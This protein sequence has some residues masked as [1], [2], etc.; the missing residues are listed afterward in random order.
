MTFPKKF[1]S[2]EV[3][4]TK[5][6]N[7]CKDCP[8]FRDPCLWKGGGD[9]PAHVI[10]IGENPSG[11]SIGHSQPFYGPQGRLFKEILKF[12]KARRNGE[13]DE[14]KYYFTYGALV[15]AYKPKATHMAHC[16]RNLHRDI[17]SVKGIDGRLP[18][19]VPLGPF[20]SKALG[21]RS[22]ITDIVGRVL[23]IKIGTNT[24]KAVPLLSMTHLKAEPGLTA[25]VIAALLRAAGLAYGKT[26]EKYLPLEEITKDYVF[27]KTIEEVK[28]LVDYVINY[29]NAKS[30]LSPDRWVISLDVETNTLKPYVPDAKVLMLSVAWDDGKAA[31]IL[32]DHKETPYDPKKAWEHVG[33]LLACNK[34]KVFHGGKFDLQ[35]LEIVNNHKVNNLAWDTLLGEHYIDEDKKGHYKLKKLTNIYTPAYT[36]YEDE[37]QALLRFGTTDANEVLYLNK[38]DILDYNDTLGCPPGR[39]PVLWTELITA[40]TEGQ[41]K[42]ILQLKKNLNIKGPAKKKKKDDG[43]ASIPLDTILRYAAVDADVTRIIMKA[44]YH[45]VKATKLRDAAN[46]VMRSFYLPGS[47]TLGRMEY[48]GIKI[49][50]KHLDKIDAGV[51][52]MLEKS[53]KEL[54]R[55]FGPG[56]NYSSP[57]QVL[58]LMT[59]MNFEALP[60]VEQGS[61]AHA[62]LEQYIRHY[63]QGD[64]HRLFCE[65]MI[66]Y[67]AP[68]TAK[69]SFIKKYRLLCENDGRIHCGFGLNT[70][71][72]GRL[73]SSGPNLQNVPLRVCRI[74][75][76]DT[77]IHPGFNVKKLFIPSSDDLTLC[78][79][80][81]KGAELRVYTAYSHDDIMIKAL[82]DGLDI[83]SFVASKAFKILYEEVVV[84]KNTDPE[85]YKKRDQAKHVVFGV[86]YGAGAYTVAKQIGSTIEEAQNI[87]N[88]IFAEFPR[89]RW[90]ID[91]T[92]RKV[93]EQQYLDTYLGRRRRFRLA[94]ANNTQAENARREGINFL[95]QSTASDLVLNQMCEMDEHMDEL[96]G[97]ILITVHDSILFELPKANIHK[98]RP[99]LDL[100]ITQRV[101][102][103]FDWLEVPFI[104]D[105]D[106][107]PSY[108]E[109]KP[110]KEAA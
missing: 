81:I 42:G 22:N 72:T 69:K 68:E 14:I 29:Q 41:K 67:R 38:K 33:R 86:F 103:Q 36:G 78:N 15:G 54:V 74:V 48:R 92:A 80:D 4:L 3:I 90:Y 19:L 61:T 109:L 66:E 56:T 106:V 20:A 24:Y 71:S 94:H 37:L 25:V 85:M 101:A 97:R 44:Q 35:F 47:R 18:I 79:V 88:L 5:K 95:I 70:T 91:T 82:N 40:F 98:I 64:V 65:K 10:I 76:D 60:G 104:Y 1:P 73:S 59:R 11:F 28:K 77:V 43:F 84:K 108:G 83:H 110:I 107:G 99:F 62:V 17:L 26:E 7:S 2:N 39:D 12:V 55:N 100:W 9:D 58:Q 105:A 57:T 87:I 23:T 31:T 30:R 63:P 16:Q 45:R 34:P 51:T 49:D 102:E 27:P 50:L 8:S 96:E 32:L 53:H 89:L 93:R 6:R 75:R 13:F 46:N 52:E 21:L